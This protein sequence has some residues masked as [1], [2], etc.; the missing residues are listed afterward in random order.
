MK[1]E[2]YSPCTSC[3]YKLCD[4]C[5]FMNLKKS[6]KRKKEQ[7]EVYMKGIQRSKRETRNALTEVEF[8]KDRIK[9]IAPDKF[10]DVFKT[11]EMPAEYRTK[12]EDRIDDLCR[13]INESERSRESLEQEVERLKR[14]PTIEEPKTFEDERLLDEYSSP[15]SRI[16][17]LERHLNAM[18]D[19]RDYWYNKTVK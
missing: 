16:I 3:M 8:I 9:K 11:V 7:L 2:L 17:Q 10:N 18:R 1:V 13:K 4:A 15:S 19:N 14:K 5:Y 12:Q 6:V